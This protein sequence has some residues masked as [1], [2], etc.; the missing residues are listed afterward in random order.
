MD[1]IGEV[2]EVHNGKA[3]V[4][5]R[6]HTAC[7]RCGACGHLAETSDMD[8]ETLNVIGARP[9]DLV[10]LSM[11]SGSVV[12]AAFLAYMLPLLAFL[13][14]LIG[15]YQ[16]GRRWVTEIR[17]EWAG[18]IGG[19]LLMVAVYFGLRSYDRRAALKGKYLPR[20]TGYFEQR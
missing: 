3:T 20:I 13:A 16:A 12:R 11:E 10:V 14:G 19:F 1:A 17:P 7:S 9:G 15:G 2:I 8:V 5:T 4:R 18:V 6:R